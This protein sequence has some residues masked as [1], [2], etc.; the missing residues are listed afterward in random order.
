MC[1]NI[2]PLFN[3]APPATDEEVHAAA[4]QYV[5][6]VS[7]TRKPSGKNAILSDHAVEQIAAITRTLVDSLETSAAP[8]DREVEAKKAIARSLQRFGPT[9]STRSGTD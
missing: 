8:K 1:R 5:R 3:F 2:R 4:L 9:Q 7:A 6:K